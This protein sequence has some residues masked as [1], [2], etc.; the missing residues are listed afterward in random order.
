MVKKP[1]GIRRLVA[2]LKKG[3]AM[4]STFTMTVLVL[5]LAAGS[6][7]TAHAGGY[8]CS[9]MNDSTCVPSYSMHLKN[10]VRRAEV[11]TSRATATMNEQQFAEVVCMIGTIASYAWGPA[12][13]ACL[14]QQLMSFGSGGR[15]HVRVVERVTKTSVPKEIS[16]R[17]AQM[18]LVIVDLAHRVEKAEMRAAGS[19]PGNWDAF[20]YRHRFGMSVQEEWRQIVPP[21]PVPAPQRGGEATTPPSQTPSSHGKREA[22]PALDPSQVHE[23]SAR[24]SWGRGL[25]VALPSHMEIAYTVLNPSQ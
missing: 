12:G 1:S 18:E 7:P 14:P 11:R 13:L 25:N 5:T 6:S 2:W 4:K 3:I 15:G 20:P 8:N 21:V 17:I 16:V 22:T 24:M 19:P 23:A 9:P 10:D